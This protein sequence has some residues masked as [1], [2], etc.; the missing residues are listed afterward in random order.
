MHTFYT[1]NIDSSIAQLDEQESKHA[2]KVLRL[3]VGDSV[4]LI[5]GKGGIA[6]GSILENHH[7]RCSVQ[8]KSKEFFEQ[9]KRI[10]IAIAPTKSND[11]I[12]WFLEKAT[13][14]G[15]TDFYPVLTKNSE[16]KNINPERWYKVVLAATKQS[17]RAWM[18]VIH[19]LHSIN[20][21]IDSSEFQ[22]KLIAHCFEEQKNVICKSEKDTVLLIGPEGDFTIEEVQLA[23]SRGFKPVSLGE[24]RLRTETA[25]VV[26]ATLLCL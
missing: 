13:E 14:I 3:S 7:K 16:R 11:R 8:I 12:E 17:Q 24:N 22:N 23:L 18:P 9:K 19:P 21:F 6:T 5:D 25:G 15:G 4:R 20:D 2:V 26:G 1:T 10:A